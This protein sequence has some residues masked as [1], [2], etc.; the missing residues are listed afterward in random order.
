MDLKRG[1][2]HLEGVLRQARVCEGQRWDI[3]VFSI[4]EDEMAEQRKKEGF[5]YMGFWAP[6]GRS[7]TLVAKK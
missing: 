2:F 4:L 5:P 1:G 7:P 3:N 6:G